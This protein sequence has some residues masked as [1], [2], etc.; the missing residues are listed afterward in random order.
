[1]QRNDAML[2]EMALRSTYYGIA[3][4]QDVFY[5]HLGSDVWQPLATECLAEV[6]GMCECAM[7]YVHSFRRNSTCAL[8]T[9]A[10]PLLVRQ[11]A[12]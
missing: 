8:L 12:V 2:Q 4:W 3:F 1:M 6:H 10:V 5:D 11:Q 7:Q 9:A